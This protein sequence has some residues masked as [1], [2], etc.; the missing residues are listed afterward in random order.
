VGIAHAIAM[1]DLTRQIED[2]ALALD[3]FVER[4]QITHIADVDLYPSS[5]GL[6]I[7]PVPAMLRNQGVEH[8]DPGTCLNKRNFKMG[9][10]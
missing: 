9:C 4:V 1:T 5:D 7:E 3:E 6:N 8:S 2:E 10:R